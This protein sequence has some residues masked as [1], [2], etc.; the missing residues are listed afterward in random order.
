MPV[1]AHRRRLLAATVL[2]LT[3]VGSVS[4]CSSSSSG[5]GAG[6]VSPAAAAGGNVST[7]SGGAATTMVN[8]V[9]VA[10][11]AAAAA[12]LPSQYKSGIRIVTSAPYPPFEMFDANQNLTGLD[13]D[14][15]KAIAAALGTTAQ[16]TSIDYNGVIPAL[17]AGKYDMVLADIGDTPDREKVLDFVDYSKQGELLVVPSGNPQHLSGLQDMCGKTLAAESGD[18]TSEYF[19]PVASY[20]RQHGLSPMTLKELPKTSDALLALKSGQVAA[21]YLGIATAADLKHQPGGNAYQLVTPAN[22]PFGYLPR[23]VG[24]GIPKSSTALRDAV[25]AALQS[26]SAHG[27]LT[28]L[29]AKYGQQRVL[30]GDVL[31]NKIAEEPLLP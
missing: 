9:P 5:G 8:G 3:F 19:A 25:Q 1:S 18:V 14:T 20:C 15:G 21:V 11:D 10:E 29:Y 6:S 31:V 27:T 17:Q 24:A 2:S 12:K 26:L 16:F 4:G 23:W 7:A 22:K 30:T 28:K 13:I